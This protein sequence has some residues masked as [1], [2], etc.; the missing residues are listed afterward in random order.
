MKSVTVCDLEDW[1]VRNPS[2]A[3]KFMFTRTYSGMGLNHKYPQLFLKNVCL[4]DLAVRTYE[5]YEAC[6]VLLGGILTQLYLV[7]ILDH[8]SN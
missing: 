2:F 8:G 6:L 1:L 5:A 3:W 7:K 4:L